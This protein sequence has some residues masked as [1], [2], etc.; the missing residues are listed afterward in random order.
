MN[1]GFSFVRAL[2]ILEETVGKDGTLLAP[3]THIVGRA[4]DY[5]RQGG[6]FDV[7]RSVSRE[8]LIS[9]V[10]RQRKD[11]FRSLHPTNSVVAIGRYARELTQDH[12]KSIY[13]GG[14]FSPY[15]KI[16]EYD[17]LIVGL[18]V[19]TEN[20]SFVHC[21]EDVWHERGRERFPA[22][23]RTREV[24]DAKVIDWDGREMVVRTRA[25]HRRIRWRNV[26]KYMAR[27]VPEE[28]CRDFTANG[29]RYFRAAS[30]ALYLK[31][32]ELARKG[33]TIYNKPLAR[34]LG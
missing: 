28:I 27:Y 32:D 8:G 9:E 12:A 7:R 19:G 33:I 24:F 23:T 34:L 13:P 18:G 3:C 6:I 30:K 2:A 14:Q 22:E 31:M 4:D 10:L 5:L 29:S 15:Y 20:L 26:P 16:V 25:A 11:A 1:L 17:G 21:V